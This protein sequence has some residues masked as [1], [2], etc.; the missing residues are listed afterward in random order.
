MPNAVTPLWLQRLQSGVTQ[1]PSLQDA[2]DLLSS[3]TVT[4]GTTTEVGQVTVNLVDCTPRSKV[5]NLILPTEPV[6]VDWKLGCRQYLYLTENRNIYLQNPIDQTCCLLVWQ[7]KDGGGALATFMTNDVGNLY[8][9]MYWMGATAPTMTAT[10]NALDMF[11]FTYVADLK[12][13]TGMYTQ[14]LEIPSA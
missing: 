2:T 8:P 4:R 12:F 14:D 1:L 9:K 13:Y 10:E 3:H 11:S 6:S 7:R 5:T